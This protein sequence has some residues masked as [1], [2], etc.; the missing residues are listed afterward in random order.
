MEIEPLA[1]I[2]RLCAEGTEG[3]GDEFYGPILRQVDLIWP[4]GLTEPLRRILGMMCFQIG[5][6]AHAYR[7]AGE[8]VD[9]GCKPLTSSAEDEQ[10]FILHRWIGYWFDHGDGWEAAAVADINRAAKK[11]NERNAA[12]KGAANDG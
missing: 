4:P 11:A 2:R 12:K 9:L 6:Y 5:K 7:D 1:E 3:H 8:F 10:A